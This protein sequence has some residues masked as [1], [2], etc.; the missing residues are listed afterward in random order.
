MCHG[1]VKIY[2]GGFY[3]WSVSTLWCVTPL[4]FVEVGYTFFQVSV[5]PTQRDV[6][7][8]HN[9]YYFT[10]LSV[11]YSFRYISFIL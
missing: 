5:L 6:G 9:T 11:K 2:P 7:L 1:W 8:D 10:I 3:I 4:R